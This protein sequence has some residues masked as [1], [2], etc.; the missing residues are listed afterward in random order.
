[1]HF[2]NLFPTDTHLNLTH[3]CMYLSI[4]FFILCIS[5]IEI[6]YTLG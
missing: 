2:S 5:I 4:E 1:M 6:G 3:P